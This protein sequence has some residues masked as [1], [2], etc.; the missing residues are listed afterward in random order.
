MTTRNDSPPKAN[1]SLNV[2]KYALRVAV[3]LSII[4]VLGFL[5]LPPLV[6]STLVEKLSAALHRPVSV[7]S[8]SI[9]PYTL[10]VQVAGLAIQEKGGVG[11]WAWR[12]HDASPALETEATSQTPAS[13]RTSPTPIAGVSGSPNIAQAQIMVTGGL[14]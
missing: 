5:V 11:K 8:I 9:N 6:K 1:A 14:R 2:R 3:A 10:S 7:V 12:R 13:V 4:G